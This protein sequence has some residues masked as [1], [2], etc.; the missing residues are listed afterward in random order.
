MS[1]ASK[2]E[3]KQKWANEKPLLDNARILSGIFITEPED[4][5]FQER[6]ENRS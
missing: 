6:H 4:E 3:A 1:D 5:D 2:R